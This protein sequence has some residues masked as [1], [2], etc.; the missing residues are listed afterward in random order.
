[1][2][3]FAEERGGDIRAGFNL[4]LQMG[5]GASEAPLF[6]KLEQLLVAVKGFSAD[7]LVLSLG[8]DIYALGPLSKVAVMREGFARLGECVFGLGLPCVIVQAV[9]TLDSNAQGILCERT[10]L[11]AVICTLAPCAPGLPLK[12]RVLR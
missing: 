6:Q 12:R 8:F 10:R 11:G 7:V 3:G 5:H 2:A 1:M 4:N 9:Q